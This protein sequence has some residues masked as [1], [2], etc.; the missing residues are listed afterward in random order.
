MCRIYNF[1]SGESLSRGENFILGESLSRGEFAGVFVDEI[2]RV[3]CQI[4]SSGN[5]SAE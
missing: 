4:I 1:I 5:E 2:K 3:A